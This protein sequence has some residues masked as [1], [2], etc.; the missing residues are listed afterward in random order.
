MSRR[1]FENCSMRPKWAHRLLLAQMT[2]TRRPYV[3][4]KFSF[5]P[6][7]LLTQLTYLTRWQLKNS[8]HTTQTAERSPSRGVAH[9]FSRS[10]HVVR[11]QLLVA[12]EFRNLVVSV[13]NGE[14]DTRLP[15]AQPVS[16]DDDLLVDPSSSSDQRT[17]AIQIPILDSDVKRR[18]SFLCG[19][20]G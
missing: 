10:M 14:L 12:Q 7:L 9:V 11:L 8:Q 5:A 16:L 1:S 13:R 15:L 4:T 18:C 17:N 2:Q 19:R 20:Q 6:A 3:K